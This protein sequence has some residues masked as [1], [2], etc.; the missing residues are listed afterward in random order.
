MSVKKP[1]FKA[2][3]MDKQSHKCV[4]SIDLQS[5]GYMTALDDARKICLENHE[6]LYVG[7]VVKL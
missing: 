5:D 2:Y 3:L 7:Q 4:L 1:S 6:H